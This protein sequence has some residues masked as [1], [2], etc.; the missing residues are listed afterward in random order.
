MPSS[1]RSARDGPPL[2]PNTTPA[3]TPRDTDLTCL[4]SITAGNRVAV[5]VTGP[6]PVWHHCVVTASTDRQAALYRRE[7]AERQ[8]RG[9]IDRRTQLLS[10]PDPAGVR[11]GSGG[12]LL[13]ALRALARDG[14]RSLQPEA[15]ARRRVLVIHSGGESRRAPLHGATGKL[16]ARLPTLLPSEACSTVFD[17]LWAV[18]SG[19]AT[20]LRAGLVVA[21][22]DVLLA[23]DP[24]T[25]ECPTSGVMGVACWGD[26]ET[27]SHHGA[28]VLSKEGAVR[29]FL[30][31]AS[32]AALR[33]AG[34]ADE[35]GRVAVDS[36]VLAFCGDAAKALARLALAGARDPADLLNRVRTTGVPLDLYTHFTSALL[37]GPEV[38]GTDGLG[39]SYIHD[40]RQTFAGTVLTVAAP[41]P[42]AFIHLGTTALYRDHLTRTERARKVFSFTR[43]VGVYT[44]AVRRAPS[45]TLV[46][47]LLQDG[48]SRIGPGALILDTEA[49]GRLTVGAGCVVDN[50]DVGEAGLTLPA[51]TV[52]KVLPLRL[53]ARSGREARGWVALLHGV[54]D[55]VDQPAASD[56]CTWLR[57]PLAAWLRA[58][59]IPRRALWGARPPEQQTL[60]NARLFPVV[61]GKDGR[62]ALDAIAWALDDPPAPRK[63]VLHW[64]AAERLS[65]AELPRNLDPAAFWRRLQLLSGRIAAQQGV[66]DAEQSGDAPIGALLRPLDGEARAV[67]MKELAAFGRRTRDPLQRCRVLQALADAATQS[68][69]R[70]AARI[71]ERRVSEA[72]GEAVRRHA[73]RTARS[74]LAVDF[75]TE[76]IATAPVRVDL[77]GGWSD[78]PPYCLERGGAV[79]NLAV[80]L[81]GRPPIRVAARPLR[82]RVVRLVSEDRGASLEASRLPALASY[83]QPSDPLAILKAGLFCSGLLIEGDRVPLRRQLERLGGGIEL[84]TRCDVPQGSGLGVSSIL[85]G[86]VLAALHTLCGRGIDIAELAEEVLHLEQMLTTG[87][88]WQDQVGGLVG[89][90]KLT[91]SE[92][93]LPQRLS[94]ERLGLSRRARVA[95]RER[96]VLYYTGRTRLAR[97]ILQRVMGRYIS[98]DPQVLRSLDEAKALAGR[99]AAALKA[100]DLDDVGRLMAGQWE[101]NKALDPGS[102]NPD[103]DAM[104]DALGPHVAG[105]KLTGAGGG[106]FLVA[107]R[108]Q[109]VDSPAATAL[110][111]CLA[112]SGAGSLHALEVNERGLHIEV[113]DAG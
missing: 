50:A 52:L 15:L 103:L 72:V 101:C 51:N 39:G 99:V 58:H 22:G 41:D 37:C 32:P 65:L 111:R 102:T 54:S 48:R 46:R 95:L 36:G 94:I 71:L 20:R 19:M 17:E 38:A 64:L 11:L 2:T 87:G 86:A 4:A 12:G 31:K 89:G 113:C 42:S 85:G 1:P 79:V 98:R 96:L 53:R 13:W 18:L 62:A 43:E 84:R 112:H 7:L 67:A 66:R 74:P 3:D 107:M 24:H 9:L 35:Q 47:S 5:A 55:D 23:F 109:A 33:G 60:W 104:F 91:T 108:R 6:Q 16:F 21:S 26:A 28:Y 27:A 34:A 59:R 82:E 68:G 97:N 75:G 83:R 56:R 81:D 105:A 29:G 90:T 92:P 44:T 40:L 77:A 93:E 73:P 57:R 8:R 110:E 106:G 76:V 63:R 100:G 69:D 70:R 78:T 80:D 45:A 14:G 88:G 25:I 10:V 61:S 30:Q 49:R